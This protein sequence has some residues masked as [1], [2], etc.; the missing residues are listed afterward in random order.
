LDI[1][2]KAP[3][4]MHP[5]KPGTILCNVHAV[6]CTITVNDSL[7]LLAEFMGVK[8]EV[9]RLTSQVVGDDVGVNRTRPSISAI[10]ATAEGAASRGL[11]QHCNWD[12]HRGVN[13]YTQLWHP[14]TATL[15]EHQPS[16][17]F[18]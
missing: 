15:S 6:D 13:D 4:K 10:A 16:Y 11:C 18:V 1:K 2:Q 9:A 17:T 7:D 3:P 5:K 14:H 8:E 12:G